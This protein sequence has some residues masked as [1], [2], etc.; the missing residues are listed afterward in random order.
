MGFV[1]GAAGNCP[2]SFELLVRHGDGREET[3]RITETRRTIGSRG[4]IRAHGYGVEPHHAELLFRDGIVGV[5]DLGTEGGTWIDGRRMPRRVLRPGRSFRIGA[6]RFQLIGFADAAAPQSNEMDDLDTRLLDVRGGAGGARVTQLPT[7]PLAPPIVDAS[8]VE[9]A[10]PVPARRPQPATPPAPSRGARKIEPPARV[11]VAEADPNNQRW[12][13]AAIGGE[14]WRATTRAE[15]LAHLSHLKRLVVVVGYQLL[16]GPASALVEALQASEYAPKVSLILSAGVAPE[17][18]DAYYRLTPGVPAEVLQRVV[19]SATR[20][21]PASNELAPSDTRAWH[22]MQ[23][24]EICAAASAHADPV[25]AAQAVEEGVAKLMNAGRVS[26]VFHDASAGAVWTETGESPIEGSAA[27]GIVGYVART[28]E[29]VHAAAVGNDPRYDAQLDNPDGSPSDGL[30]AVPI[31]ARG[32]VHA[33]IVVRR[34]GALGVFDPK[35]CYRLVHLAQELGPIFARVS[36]AVTAEDALAQ[37]Q[38]PKAMSIYRPEAVDHYLDKGEEGEVIRIAP[39]W[40]ATMYWAL[41]AMLV[42]GVIGV[43]VGTISEYSAGPAVIRQDGRAEVAAVGAGAVASVDV[44]P[45]QR[46]TTG[47]ILARLRDVTQRAEYEAIRNDFRTQLRNRLLDPNDEAAASAVV[48]L[49]RQLHAA[50]AALEQ[51]VVRAPHDGVVTD[52]KVDPGQQIGVGDAVMAVVD[53]KAKGLEIIAFLPGGDR[54]LIEPGMAL[55]LELAGFDYAYQEV[56]VDTVTD[57]VIGPAE[58]RRILGPQ[59]A[60]TL[61]MDGGGVIMVRATLPTTTFESD[62]KVYPYHDGMGGT[63]EVRTRDETILEML[64]PAL[65]ELSL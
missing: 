8:A 26:C 14:C 46:V 18:D 39:H 24:F 61:P 51:R 10:R 54:P 19:A 17:F 16:D 55:R 44:Q 3:L 56:E 48:S 47:Q 22:D 60:D 42:I 34:P 52:I 21:R 33:V 40:T 53:D 20:P 50:E 4:D 59:L 28:A 63:A 57:G 30:F 9:R 32:E 45:G 43:A 27:T 1:E 23:V 35:T 12:L 7:S 37:R 65:K 2:A 6:T 11:V 58:A 38:R 64:I 62:G 15:V 36:A 5:R 31:A 49:R 41:L 25:A 13:V 29:P